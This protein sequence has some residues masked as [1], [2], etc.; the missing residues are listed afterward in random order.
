MYK[1][2]KAFTDLNDG[3]HEYKEG[4]VYPRA[5]YSPSDE[6]IAELSGV[7]N[8]RHVPLIEKAATRKKKTEA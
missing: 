5:G 6:R 8:L 4:D 1:V 2:I 3:L 7:N